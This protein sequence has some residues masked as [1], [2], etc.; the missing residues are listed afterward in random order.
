LFAFSLDTLDG[1]SAGLI[2]LLIYLVSTLAIF[3]LFIILKSRQEN[4]VSFLE[5]KHFSSLK[6]VNPSLV[7]ILAI[8]LFSMAGIPPLG[9][10][11]SKFLVFTTVL[12]EGTL[13]VLFLIVVVSLFTAYY[14][15]RPIKILLFHTSKK[16]AFFTELTYLGGLFISVSFFNNL[17]LFSVPKFFW[18]IDVI[19]IN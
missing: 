1:V 4:S 15:I 9:G 3:Y 5:F 8:N 10:F 18:F 16:P 19:L 7:F 6:L 11:L 12:E 13:G 17:V 2:Y 14:Y